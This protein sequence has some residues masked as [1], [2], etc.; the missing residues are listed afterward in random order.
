MSSDST[1]WPG[2]DNQWG[3]L[4]PANSAFNNQNFRTII[5]FS[6]IKQ[7]FLASLDNQKVPIP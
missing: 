4:I 2:P 6:K 7:Q 5:F 1:K 3:L